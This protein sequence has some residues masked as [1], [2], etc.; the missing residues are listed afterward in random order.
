MNITTTK[1]LAS[2]LIF[3]LLGIGIVVLAGLTIQ[4]S[5]LESRLFAVGVRFQEFP[6]LAKNFWRGETSIPL[7]LQPTR[8][9]SDAFPLAGRLY[10][11]FG[12]LPAV[13]FM[14]LVWLAGDIFPTL[15]VT[16]LLIVLAGGLMFGLAQQQG[17]KKKDAL[18]I[19]G[20]YA[21]GSALTPLAIP[22]FTSWSVQLLASVFFAGRIIR[23][24]F[25]T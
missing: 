4:Q 3:L 19:A 16:F 23:T 5:F 20:A 6:D 17:L 7:G 25:A 11:P 9:Y 10:L 21:L 18:W 24:F 1:K 8:Y 14:P 13:I 15:T 12:P 2:G 22:L